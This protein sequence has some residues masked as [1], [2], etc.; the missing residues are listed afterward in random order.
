MITAPLPLWEMQT[1]KFDTDYSN[2]RKDQNP[3]QLSIESRMHAEKY[4]SDSLHV[5]T[6]G[7]VLDSGDAVAAFTIPHIIQYLLQ[8]LLQS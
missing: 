5:Y 3:L 4:Y 8:N 2:I 7:S 6:D 1:A